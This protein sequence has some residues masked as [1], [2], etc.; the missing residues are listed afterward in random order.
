[1]T[2]SQQ[3]MDAIVSRQRESRSKFAEMILA[4]QPQIERA[5]PR[6]MVAH[7]FMRVATTSI[8][9]SAILTKCTA[10]SLVAGVYQA[11]QLGLLLD[12][13]LGHAAL[14][15]YKIRGVYTAQMQIMYRGYAELAY[16]TG[17]VSTI[18]AHAIRKGDRFD[19]REGSNPTIDYAKPLDGERGDLIG[20][21][22]IARMR[23][24][25]V[26]FEVLTLAE[27]HKHRSSSKAYAKAERE[28]K[29][30]SPWHEWEDAMFK[31]TAI[32]ELSKTLPQA[33]ELQRAAT[34]DEARDQGRATVEEIPPAVPDGMQVVD[35]EYTEEGP[36][37]DP[38]TGEV[39]PSVEE[40]ERQRNERNE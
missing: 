24:G 26:N 31:K 40:L 38:E 19:Y 34:H 4:R 8:E 27:V 9:Q 14:V 2:E 10:Q 20:A 15:P 36:E 22:S 13:V 28:K 37:T 11:A 21:F 17:L 29:F 25:G 33:T 32:R 39:V 23:D 1:M 35:A 5:L 7:A 6:H 16:R 12:G 30:D 18:S 3:E